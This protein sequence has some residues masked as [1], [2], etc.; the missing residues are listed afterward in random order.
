MG[1]VAKDASL[2]PARG[3]SCKAR[4]ERS[5]EAKLIGNGSS[6]KNFSSDSSLCFDKV[7]R[8]IAARS[9]TSSSSS[10]RERC[11]KMDTDG[12]SS[13]TRVANTPSVETEAARTE[14]FSK[15]TRLYMKRMYF[16]GDE[17]EGPRVP[18]KYKI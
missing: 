9:R 1:N 16:E 5:K 8:I 14:E 10:P 7:D 11:S 4:T 3:L 2:S 18:I 13:G 17:V 6:N 12:R 15:I